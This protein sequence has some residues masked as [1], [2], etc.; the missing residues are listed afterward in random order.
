VI[1]ARFIHVGFSFT[2]P[3]PTEAL[4]TVFNTALDWLRYEE[5]CWILYTTTDIETWRDRIRN[6]PG[7]RASDA[8]FLCVFDPKAANSYSGYMQKFAWDWLHKDRSS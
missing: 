1:G 5:H 4:E 6:A 3:A 8:F 2:G 7:L